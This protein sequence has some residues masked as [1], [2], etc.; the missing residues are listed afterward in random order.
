M[1][2]NRP[3]EI[4]EEALPGIG[5]RDDFLTE[6]NRRVGVISY[7][8]GRRD[9]LIYAKGDPDSCSE[10]VSLTE[11]E[12]DTLAEFLGTRRVIE[13]LASISEQV[14][15]LKTVNIPIL[16][17]TP[18]IGLTL[19]DAQ[20][21]NRTS[22]SVVAVWRRGQIVASPHQDFQLKMGDEL[23]TIGTEES[24]LAATAL[25]NGE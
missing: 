17:G 10:T 15:S 24:L 8:D 20:I 1:P 6:K 19:G 13:R 18:F 21:R 7:R 22:A 14:D 25:L 16:P 4:S 11:A 23:I 5:V 3:I 9:L 12:A 2:Q